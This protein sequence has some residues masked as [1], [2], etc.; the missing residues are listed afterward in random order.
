VLAGQATGDDKQMMGNIDLHTERHPTVGCIDE[1]RGGARPEIAPVDVALEQVAGI[2]AGAGA[3]GD[4]FRRGCARHRDRFGEPLGES[5]SGEAEAQD[6][7]DRR[8]GTDETPHEDSSRPSGLHLRSIAV[9][10]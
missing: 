7:G 6:E 10:P 8:S 3:G 4:A 9:C 1:Q 5:G 2:E